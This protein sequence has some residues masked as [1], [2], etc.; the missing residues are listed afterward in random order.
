MQ[1]FSRVPANPFLTLTLARSLDIPLCI[2]FLFCV[3]RQVMFLLLISYAYGKYTEFACR[4]AGAHIRRMK[5]H[6][7]AAREE[8]MRFRL[9]QLFKMRGRLLK[10]KGLC[11]WKAN[12]AWSIHHEAANADRTKEACRI[13]GR[14]VSDRARRAMAIR[15]MRLKVA[16]AAMS[17]VIDAAS[18]EGD[19][20]DGKGKGAG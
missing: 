8:V 10:K 17:A 2:F 7:K 16:A 11:T 6:A 9:N 13:L 20:K 4:A 5:E 14:L 12:D 15:F 18:S 1:D 3:P 19:A